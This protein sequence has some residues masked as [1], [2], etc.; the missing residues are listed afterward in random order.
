L[1]DLSNQKF[2][3]ISIHI[4]EQQSTIPINHLGSPT[5]DPTSHLN[6]DPIAKMV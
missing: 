4:P 3:Q 6:L 2:P 1:E 5:K